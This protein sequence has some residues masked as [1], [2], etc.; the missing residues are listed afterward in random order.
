MDL[1]PITFLVTLAGIQLLAAT[2]PGPAFA[3]ATQRSFSG[4]RAAGLAVEGPWWLFVA[5]A[6]STDAFRK[7]YASV[8]TYID[9]VMGDVLS[10]PGLKLSLDPA[11]IKRNCHDTPSTIEKRKKKGK[12]PCAFIMIAT[13][14]SI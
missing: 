3:V 8:K 14:T 6:F 7:R 4:G 2:S 1:T 11:R 5:M 10:V 9:R 12:S 13:P